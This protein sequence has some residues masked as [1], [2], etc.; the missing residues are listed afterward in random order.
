MVAVFDK[1]QR[2]GRDQKQNSCPGRRGKGAW[3]SYAQSPELG[4]H[5]PLN[6]AAA[7]HIQSPFH[8]HRFTYTNSQT[9]Q[10][11]QVEAQAMHS[12]E[13]INPEHAIAAR[14]GDEVKRNVIL[15]MRPT[16]V[17]RSDQVS[18]VNRL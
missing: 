16:C 17:P 12:E 1:L 13:T 11:A 14:F 3:T 2:G 4:T 10:V 5:I 15:L 8:T 18:S 9:Q 7:V 6:R